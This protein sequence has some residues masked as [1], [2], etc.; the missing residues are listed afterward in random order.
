MNRHF[1]ITIN[2][3]DEQEIEF[4]DYTVEGLNE[5]F[6]LFNLN[7]A[8]RDFGNRIRFLTGQLERGEETGRLHFQLYLETTESMRVSTVVN[9]FKA[10]FGK[11]NSVRVEVRQG[12]QE[13]AISYVT[14][15]DTRVAG[16]GTYGTKAPSRAKG[17]PKH[18]S[19]LLDC[20]NRGLKPKDIWVNHP[21]V[22]MTH[23][24]FIEHLQRSGLY[25]VSPHSEEE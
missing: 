7:P 16:P 23:W 4:I 25:G 14:K 3:T 15:E 22:Y 5:Y 8:D 2:L 10:V 20:I 17:K 19:V 18:K 11:R 13:Q 9:R 24:R 1:V 6:E 12:S 21:D